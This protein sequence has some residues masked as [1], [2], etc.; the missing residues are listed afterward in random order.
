[1]DSFT[2]IKGLLVMASAYWREKLEDHVV[3]MYAEDLSEFSVEEIK[4]ALSQLRRDPKV[5]RFPLPAVI[6]SAIRPPQTADDAAKEAAAR[7]MAAVPK[8][9]WPNQAAAREYIGELGW[10][11]VQM[12]GGW[13]YLCET[14]KPSMIPTLQA[15]FRELAKTTHTRA[16]T[17]TS[18]M[19]PGLPEPIVKH[20]QIE[21]PAQRQ[22]DW[23]KVV[24]E[25]SES[26]KLED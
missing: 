24:L 14:L 9:G 25:L 16:L 22:K 8:F 5:T 15:Q 21:A 18:D 10:Q 1:M 11:V 13:P 12:Q 4:A 3:E 19:P 6:A 17:G 20:E 23:A 7:I 2:A 26:K